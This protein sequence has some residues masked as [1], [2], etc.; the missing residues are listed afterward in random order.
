MLT[1]KLRRAQ[2]LEGERMLLIVDDDHTDISIY[3]EPTSRIDNAIKMK[4]PRKVL[5]REKVGGTCLIAYDESKRMLSVCSP[6]KVRLSSTEV[7]I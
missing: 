4:H 5:K 7:Q 2:L 3:L 1:E 6:K